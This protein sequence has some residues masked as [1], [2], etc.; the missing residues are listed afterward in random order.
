VTDTADLNEWHFMGH[1]NRKRSTDPKGA[2][3]SFKAATGWHMAVR[4]LPLTV[5]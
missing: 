2:P 5:W 1:I 4:K 3:T